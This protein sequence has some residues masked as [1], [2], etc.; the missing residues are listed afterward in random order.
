[1]ADQ[2]KERRE[3]KRNKLELNKRSPRRGPSANR[4]IDGGHSESL[5]EFKK[6]DTGLCNARP[7]GK[8]ERRKSYWGREN[9]KSRKPNVVRKGGKLAMQFIW[10]RP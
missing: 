4:P 2:R 8:E 1:M 9:K 5:T 3:S 10:A 7:G 6:S